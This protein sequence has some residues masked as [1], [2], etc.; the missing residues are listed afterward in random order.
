MLNKFA[1]SLAIVV[2]VACVC[3]AQLVEK[4]PSWNVGRSV[5]EADEELIDNNLEKKIDLIK[6]HGLDKKPSWMVGR[7]LG[8]E[9][10]K[11]LRKRIIEF[12]K[13]IEDDLELLNKY[14]LLNELLSTTRY[15]DSL[16][17]KRPSNRPSR[18]A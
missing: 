15:S 3:Q 11:D 18:T 14:K 8:E 7:D 6:L 17:N 10:E 4:R 5:E 1:L 12:K 9:G 16:R 2:L 13:D